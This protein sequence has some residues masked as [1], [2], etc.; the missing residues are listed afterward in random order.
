MRE[1]PLKWKKRRIVLAIIGA[2]RAAL[3]ASI[4]FQKSNY[5][6][7]IF[8]VK[9][10][11]IDSENDNE[12]PIVELDELTLERLIEMKF[13]KPLIESLLQLVMMNSTSKLAELR[14]GNW[15]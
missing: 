12:F 1:F 4:N 8:S 7:T 5:E 10:A 14:K 13:F 9:Q 11:K 2:N 6:V 15:I 3:R